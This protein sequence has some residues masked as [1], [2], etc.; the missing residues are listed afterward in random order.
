MVATMVSPVIIRKNENE[1]FCLGNILFDYLQA[2]LFG[3][4]VFIAYFSVRTKENPTGLV[5]QISEFK[6]IG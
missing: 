1:N 2:F 3:P 6:I 5:E 4:K